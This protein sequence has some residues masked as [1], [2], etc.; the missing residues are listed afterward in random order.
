ME[1]EILEWIEDGNALKIG[2]DT[3]VEQT[4][5]WKRKFTTKELKTFYQKEYGS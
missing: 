1:Q 3:W 4:T 5:Q 2:P